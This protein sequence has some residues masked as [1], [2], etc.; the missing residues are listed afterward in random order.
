M[1]T[2][3]LFEKAMHF[4]TLIDQGIA[5]MREHAEA[6]AQAEANYRKAKS[7][8]WIRCPNDDTGVK[9]GEREWTAARR[10]AW[11]DAQCADLRYKRD[12][13]EAM[14]QS[15]LEAVRSRRAQL[16]ALQTFV[17]AERAEAEFARTGP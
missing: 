15:A 11:V 4:S 16:S 2:P 8:A 3:E 12:L 17:N 13:A 1:N 9:A 14:K 7:E 6:Y 5:A 10:E